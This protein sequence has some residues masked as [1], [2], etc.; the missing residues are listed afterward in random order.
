MHAGI[1]DPQKF[2]LSRGHVH[3][4]VLALGSFFVQ[5]LIDR[6][7]FGGVFEVSAHHLIQGAPQVRGT[8]FGHGTALGLRLAGLVDRRVHPGKAHQRA[9]P[10][11]SAYILQVNWFIRL[12]LTVELL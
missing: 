1:I 2:I 6:F 12:I 10:R 5:K 8:A 4:V 11:K 9:A 3:E 7:M